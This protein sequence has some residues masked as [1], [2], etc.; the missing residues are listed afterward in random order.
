LLDIYEPKHAQGKVG[1]GSESKK[2]EEKIVSKL[3]SKR[4]GGLKSKVY[5]THKKR[6]EKQGKEKH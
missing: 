5:R 1:E 4:G 2:K 6:E 3:G